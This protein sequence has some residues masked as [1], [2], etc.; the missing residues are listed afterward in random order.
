[1]QT[2]GRSQTAEGVLCKCACLSTC[3]FAGFRLAL[4]KISVF[5]KGREQDTRH[6]TGNQ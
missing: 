6:T 1:M 5:N 4:F 2:G 3:T